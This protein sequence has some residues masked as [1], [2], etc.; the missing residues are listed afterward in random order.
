MHAP[1]KPLFCAAVGSGSIS[2]LFL[3]IK[4]LVLFSERLF[5]QPPWLF[6]FPAPPSSLHFQLSVWGS[7]TD[8]SKPSFFPWSISPSLSPSAFLFL[9]G[10]PPRLCVQM[11]CV[12]TSTP[13]NEFTPLQFSRDVQQHRLVPAVRLG[14][15][16][17]SHPVP[18]PRGQLG[19]ARLGI[20]TCEEGD[21]RSQ[22]CQKGPWPMVSSR[23]VLSR[24][25]WNAVDGQ[26]LVLIGSR[27]Y[28]IRTE[29]LCSPLAI[30]KHGAPTCLCRQMDNGQISME[31]NE[32]Y[33]NEV[34]CCR[35]ASYPCVSIQTFWRKVLSSAGQPQG[36]SDCLCNFITCHT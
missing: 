15:L 1:P 14:Y 20:L 32:M 28:W 5:Y 22:R 10:P 8:R 2:R 12:I 21:R 33:D 16:R 30:N 17:F 29:R 7:P 6:L 27:I 13:V 24:K 34:M 3:A 11:T 4:S 9:E 26:M 35:T 31:C 19:V 36:R 18:M 23:G 25:P